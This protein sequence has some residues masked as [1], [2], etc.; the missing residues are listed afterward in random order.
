[1]TRVLMAEGADVNAVSVAEGKQMKNGLLALGVMTPLLSTAAY[2]GPEEVKM[3]LDAGAKVNVQDV[4]GMT[5]LM[6]AVATDGADA[7]VVKL[8][9]AK[10]ADTAI[11]SK[12][13]EPAADWAKKFANPQI[14]A[15][16]RMAKAQPSPPSP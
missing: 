11:K 16:L 12:N 1:M 10:G 15:A 13:G 8:L 9:I 14:L 7:R 4:R 5:P 3:L 2:G 6:L